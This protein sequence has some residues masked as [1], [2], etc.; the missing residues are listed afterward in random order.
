MYWDLIVIAAIIIVVVCCFRRFSSFV[1]VVGIIDI[2]LRLVYFFAHNIG[3]P[4][5]LA[6]VNRVGFPASIPDVINKYTQDLLATVLMW[7]FFGVM[8][9]F[10]FYV[11]RT[12]WHKK[13]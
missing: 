12:F 1:Y 3:V 6:L 13:K 10:E 11:V 5:I 2:F 9:V 4:E 8:V 7:C